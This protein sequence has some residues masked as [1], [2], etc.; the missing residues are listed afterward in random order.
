MVSN[1]CRTLTNSNAQSCQ[2]VPSNS[3]RT[4]VISPAVP[5]F[6]LCYSKHSWVLRETWVISNPVSTRIFFGGPFAL[7]VHTH[8]SLHTIA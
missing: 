5:T 2:T 3:C 8:T 7:V 4:S 6:V 1:S